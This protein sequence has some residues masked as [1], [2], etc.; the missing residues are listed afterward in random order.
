MIQVPPG[1]T[2]EARFLAGVPGT[3]QYYASAGGETNRGRPF[4][5]DSQMYGAFIVDSPGSVAS[6][7]VFV[8]GVWRSQ[9]TPALSNDVPV[10]NGKSWPYTERLTYAAGEEVRWRW[11][12]ASDLNHPMHMH[13]SYYRVDSTGD[14]ERDQI[15]SPAEQRRTYSASR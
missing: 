6:D 10:I 13:G 8:I 9:A 11:I 7:R 4:R 15:F 3:Y 12:N 2:R 1:E 14:G 5:E